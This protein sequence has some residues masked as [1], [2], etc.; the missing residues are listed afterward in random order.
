MELMF[1][2]IQSLRFLDKPRSFDGEVL[3]VIK[4]RTSAPVSNGHADHHHD[5]VVLIS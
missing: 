5:H 3:V 1:V 4:E 2:L